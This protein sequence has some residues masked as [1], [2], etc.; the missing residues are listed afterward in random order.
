M[1]V[2]LDKE[3]I[4]CMA[5]FQAVTNVSAKDCIVDGGRVSYVVDKGRKWAAI[6]TGGRKSKK[7]QERIGKSVKIY[8]YDPDLDQFILNLLDGPKPRSVKIENEIVV[9]SLNAEDKGRVVGRDGKNI[10]TLA[11]ILKRHHNIERLKI[12]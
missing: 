11:R 6:G 12:V 9:V 7:V 3:T 1:S 2:K 8:E 10:K 4:E 5:I